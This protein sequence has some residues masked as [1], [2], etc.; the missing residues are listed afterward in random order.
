MIL[1]VTASS[2]VH[3]RSGTC[4]KCTCITLKCWPSNFY[5]KQKQYT[6]VERWNIPLFTGKYGILNVSNLKANVREICNKLHI[7]QKKKPVDRKISRSYFSRSVCETNVFWKTGQLVST[8]L[9]MELP[10][11]NPKLSTVTHYKVGVLYDDIVPRM[12]IAL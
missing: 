12:Y 10:K 1:A 8:L 3:N 2:K 5:H 6:V 11:F 4:L 9:Q 7:C